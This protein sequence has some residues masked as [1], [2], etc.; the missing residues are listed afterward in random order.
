MR[1]RME[2]NVAF[3]FPCRAAALERLNKSKPSATTS[4]PSAAASV[5]DS[6]VSFQSETSR[7]FSLHQKVD[8]D[9]A[10]A[11]KLSLNQA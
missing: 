6:I 1:S 5:S 10:L 4:T 2:R 11:I 3:S 9:L 8:D 7:F